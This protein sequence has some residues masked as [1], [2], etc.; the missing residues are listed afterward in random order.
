ME[1]CLVIHGHFYQP[2]RE[3]AWTESIVRQD[4]AH[5][6][7]DWNERI[8]AE[9]YRPNAF[10]RIVDHTN[11]IVN[12]VNNYEQ[13][14]FNFGPT[15]LSW[16]ERYSPA[17]YRRI[18]A[19]DKA[20]VER[21]HGHGNAI[22]QAYNHA[23]LPLCNA[24]DKVTQVRWG[25]ADFRYRFGREPEAMWLPETAVN[26]A[27]LRVLV[28]HGMKFVI[29]S[30]HQAKRIRSFAV[31]EIEQ[32]R[33]EHEADTT[34][35]EPPATSNAQPA[36]SDQQPATSNQLPA[37]I[38]AFQ[39]GEW[40][41]VEH[42]E[43]DTRQ[44]Y[45]WFDKDAEGHPVPERYI[46]IFF[47][48]GGLS[49]GVGFEHL[50]RDAGNFAQS[51]DNCFN[52]NGTTRPELVSI[53]TDGETYGHHE[54]YGDMGLAF[55]LNVEAP[56]RHIRVTNYAEFL[57]ENPPVMEVEIKEGPNGEGTAWSCAHGVGRWD[58]HCGCRGDGPREWTQEWRGPLRQALD[59]LRDT[60]ATLTLEQGGDVLHDV[61]E[62]RND[63]IDVILRRTP[64]SL[65]EFFTR[66]QKRELAEAERLLVIHLMEMQRQTQLM[67][68]SCGWFFTELSGIETVQVIQYAAR[69]VRLAE[70]ITKQPYE[71]RFL[72]DLKKARSNHHDFKNGEG[73]YR[74]LVWPASVSFTRL[75]NT[76]AIR[77]LFAGA[78]AQ[79]RL[80]HYT[81]NRTDLV[82]KR[83]ED[84]TFMIGRAEVESG[85]TTV[86]RAYAFALVNRGAGEGVKSFV[87]RDDGSWNY[88]ESREAL[89][90]DFHKL[91]HE[92]AD[93][94]PRRWGGETYDLRDMLA[95]ERQQVID[96]LLQDR[97]SEISGIYSHI[98]T[99]YRSLMQA[100]RGL[101]AALPA[102]L[103]VP[104]R[105][106]LSQ[107]LREE[108]EKLRNVTDPGAYKP[109]LEVARAAQRLGLQ[110]D[111]ESASRA[112]QE[113][114]EQR[115]QLVFNNAAM[116]SCKEIL[117]LVDIADRLKLALDEPSIQNQVF[118]ILNERVDAMI[119]RI[120]AA[121]QIEPAYDAVSD[122]L[123]LA[124]RFNFN[125][126]RYKD[127]LKPLE[128][129]WS[130]DP[131]YWP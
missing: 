9:C 116:E 7:H 20:S 34:G 103:S 92:I 46:D 15:L 17:T 40:I 109:C 19:A 26:D 121:A 12:I 124:Y 83:T 120:L 39:A 68:T 30:P 59:N 62:A 129:A 31:T 80:Y 4:S 110:L 55:L 24:R 42:G 6:Y 61:W 107:R 1:K 14:S 49:R 77:T 29:L 50:L 131:R 127:R 33:S 126:K 56:R 117:V 96:I 54:R 85:I 104:A 45:R 48:D 38:K 16:L 79:E 65:A 37:S 125:I 13:V 94:L 23:I 82:E 66:H 71:A 89:I 28:D 72:S 97:L 119:D 78:P 21:F 112:F 18:L 8:N 101:G 2:P 53:A 99:Q 27:T 81:I 111:N 106:T 91:E 25:I 69:A 75:V 74:K 51:I 64:E 35:N 90:N 67:Y 41:G 98:Y 5:P 105:Y 60:L 3:N 44:A 58:R 57:A 10:A 95:E 32:G 88:A 86:R 36:T 123:R 73:V 70:H 84:T 118:S 114:I 115:L 122:F 128:Q 43:I 93:D 100:L 76:H 22:A 52:N 102:E 11:R 47:Y 108:V 63:Y 87:K 130:Q 113:M